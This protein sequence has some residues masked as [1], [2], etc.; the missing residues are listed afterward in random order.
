M[1]LTTKVGKVTKIYEG[2]PAEI[3]EYERG[4]QPKE[5]S[6]QLDGKEIAKQVAWEP[7]P[8]ST[9]TR[10]EVVAEAKRDVADRFFEGHEGVGEVI[11]GFYGHNKVEFT[12]NREKR[13]VVALLDLAYCPGNI[14]AKGIAKAAPDDVFNA[15][16][17]KAIALR[18]AL[19]LD[20]PSEYTNAP[21]PEGV[22]VGDVV[23]SRVNNSGNTWIA[24]TN[25]DSHIV[26]VQLNGGSNRSF[27]VN[28]WILYV[29]DDTDRR[30]YD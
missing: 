22:R 8:V 29:I 30:D 21:K 26:R 14:R 12:V 17:G 25:E 4:E 2:T 5:I 20:V 9:P 23:K 7:T 28:K 13:T 3:R 19:G 24:T 18:R 27:D 15:D 16:I 10:A 11:K 1:K 6:I